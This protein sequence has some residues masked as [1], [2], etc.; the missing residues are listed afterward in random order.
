[1]DNDVDLKN[2][3]VWNVTVSMTASLIAPTRE[4]AIQQVMDTLA[5]DFDEGFGPWGKIL[6]FDLNEITAEEDDN[7]S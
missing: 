7:A 6:P 2:D 3:P 1:M 5:Y 4:H